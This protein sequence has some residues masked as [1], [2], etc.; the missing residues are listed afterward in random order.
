[1]QP[2]ASFKAIY[3]GLAIAVGGL[4]ADEASAQMAASFTYDHN[5]SEMLVKR[6]RRRVTITYDKPRSALKK[7]GVRTGT[8]LFQGRLDQ[9]GILEGNAHIFSASCGKTAY[10]VHGQYDEGRSFTLSGAAPVFENC[11]IVDNRYDI[12]HAKTGLQSKENR[13]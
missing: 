1:M 3:I 12:A 7:H 13:R 9:D 5:G 11:R 8:M 6:D 10:Y 4:L 2:L